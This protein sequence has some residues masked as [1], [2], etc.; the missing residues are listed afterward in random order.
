MIANRRFIAFCRGRVLDA[1]D[2]DGA[3]SR[4]GRAAPKRAFGL[5]RS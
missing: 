5:A 4:L 1:S 3:A 2:P